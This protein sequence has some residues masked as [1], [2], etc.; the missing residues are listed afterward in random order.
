MRFRD[1]DEA[2]ENLFAR[3]DRDLDAVLSLARQSAMFD[4]DFSPESLR[5][6][7]AW[8]FTSGKAPKLVALEEGQ[9][10]RGIGAYFGEVLVRN[11]SFEWFVTEYAFA[12]GRFDIGVRRGGVAVMLTVSMDLATR[13]NNAR[14]ES[15][16]R[17]YQKYAA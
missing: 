16:W 5:S 12:P 17:A 13:P 15:L 3:R 1:L 9:L 14:K 10:E 7:E 8:Y 4:P 6:L 11:K 2:R